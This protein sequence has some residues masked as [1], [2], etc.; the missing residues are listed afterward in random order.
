MQRLGCRRDD[1]SSHAAGFRKEWICR[2]SVQRMQSAQLQQTQILSQTDVQAALPA[3]ARCAE[4]SEFEDAAVSAALL[5]NMSDTQGTQSASTAVRKSTGFGSFFTD[6]VEDLIALDDAQWKAIAPA[7]PPTVQRAMDCVTA[8][9]GTGDAARKQFYID[10]ENFTFINH[11][12]FGGCLRAPYAVARAWQDY[13]EAQ[14]LRFLD[15]CIP[16]VQYFAIRLKHGKSHFLTGA[17]PSTVAHQAE[18][19]LQNIE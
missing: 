4:P 13:C 17:S 11:G 16:L 6:N 9:D 2:R 5:S 14:P 1:T 15:R 19:A 12:A 10:F 3:L 18:L 7:L 8:P